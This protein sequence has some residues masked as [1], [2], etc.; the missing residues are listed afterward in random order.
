MDVK[1]D[2]KIKEHDNPL[3]LSFQ[4]EDPANNE[5]DLDEDK[6]E[7]LSFPFNYIPINV[8][9]KNFSNNFKS[10][11]SLDLIGKIS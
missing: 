5:I 8:T 10:K 1:S 6:Q 7:I 3:L 11:I 9:Q 4:G 2:C